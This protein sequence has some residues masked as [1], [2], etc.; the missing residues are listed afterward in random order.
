MPAFSTALLMTRVMNTQTMTPQQIRKA[1]MEVLARELG[2]VGMIRFMQQCE[3]GQGDY[4]KDRHEWLDQ[5]SVDEIA[6]MKEKR[7][8]YRHSK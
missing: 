1:G 3:M 4:S 5:Y 7:G 2:V 6:R 8:T